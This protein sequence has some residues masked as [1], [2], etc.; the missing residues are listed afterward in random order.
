[1]VVRQFPWTC[2]SWLGVFLW[3]LIGGGCSGTE[4]CRSP[5][6]ISGGGEGEHQFSIRQHC[7]G[8]RCLSRASRP[9][10]AF[11]HT[12]ATVRG[13]PQSKQQ[14]PVHQQQQQQPLAGSSLGH[15]AGVTRVAGE[16]C[17]GGGDCATR[18][19]NGTLRDCKGIECHLPL[20]IRQKPRPASHTA[21]CSPNQGEGC[22][23]PALVR[24]TERAAQF[25]GEDLAY[26]ATELGGA[27][28]GVQLTCD[29]K[30]GRWHT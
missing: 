6:C 9:S 3:L 18:A 21:P 17:S 12:T 15:S 20:R 1:M 25:I 8:P 5:P 30:P 19:P 29:V 28:L 26:T 16:S 11:V 2:G 13:Q 23:E 27:T 14:L 4:F 24:L 22:P 10:R 7:Q